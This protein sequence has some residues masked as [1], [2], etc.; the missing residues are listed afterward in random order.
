MHKDETSYKQIVKATSV[1]GGVQFLIIVVA[2]IRLKFVAILIGPAGIGIVGLFTTTL[3]LIAGLTNFG[4]KTSSV[5]NIAEANA[6]GDYK[7]VAFTIN[8]FRKLVWATGILGSLVVLFSAQIL[9][10]Y[11]FGN[12]DYT[13]SFIWLSITLLLNQISGGQIA[14]LEGM[15]LIKPLAKASLFG[16]VAGLFFAVPIYYI[17]GI[18]GIVPVFIITSCVS[19]FLS[20]WFT[21]NI[22]IEKIQLL[23]KDIAVEGKSMIIMGFL[24][25]LTAILDNLIEYFTRIFIANHGDISMVGLF[26][27]GFAIVNTYVGMIFSAMLIDYYP[28]LSAV[29]HDNIRSKNLINEQA[30]IAVLALGPLVIFFLVFI[31]LIIKTLYSDEF[32][33][34]DKMMYWAMLGILIKAVNWSIGIIFLAKGASKLYFSTYIFAFIVILTTNIA[35]Y[36]YFGLEGL[37]IAFLVSN[38]LLTILGYGITRHL[39]S[40][41]FTIGFIRVFLIQMVLSLL[42]FV[43]VLM[44][45]KPWSYII[46]ICLLIIS[47]TYSYIQLDRRID[48]KNA[49]NNFKNRKNGK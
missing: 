20:Y 45:A 11:T 44:I 23:T 39:Y 17:W 21:K 18:E 13:S 10:N 36:Y 3:G 25:G 40:F 30:E 29:S 4:L 47:L 43:N 37:G 31:K 14:L 27:A 16:S 6:S 38:I 34:I 35:G 32:L 2:I 1:F 22:K 24:I 41:S 19:L 12:S 28:R 42:C 49:I 15:R 7:K 5:K 33:L 26:T 46:G 8:V 9:S 48:F